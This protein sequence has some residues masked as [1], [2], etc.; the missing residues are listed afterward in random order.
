MKTEV[1]IWSVENENYYQFNKLNLKFM[2]FR[3]FLDR[4]SYVKI[5]HHKKITKL[6]L[7][8]YLNY[9]LCTCFEL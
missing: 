6:L 1:T 9:L 8:N 3:R 5:Q 4:N 7:I 2:K